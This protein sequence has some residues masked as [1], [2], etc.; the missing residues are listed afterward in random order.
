[1]TTSNNGPRIPNYQTEEERRSTLRKIYANNPEAL[2]EIEWNGMRDEA[3]SCPTCG[4]QHD[5]DHDEPFLFSCECA[6]RDDA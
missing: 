5:A 2:R 4:V 3:P 6:E 1:M